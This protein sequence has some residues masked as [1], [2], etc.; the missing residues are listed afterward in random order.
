MYELNG[1]KRIEEEGKIST[2]EQETRRA[3]SEG[4]RRPSRAQEKTR[5]RLEEEE[6]TKTDSEI[7]TTS[8]L[9]ST[10]TYIIEGIIDI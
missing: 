6:L 4:G 3:R 10:C 9:T 2:K 1:K 5:E 7:K 8:R